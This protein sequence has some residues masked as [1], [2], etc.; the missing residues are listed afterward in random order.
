MWNINSSTCVYVVCIYWLRKSYIVH[1][2]SSF[3]KMQRFDRVTQ[4]V[5][6]NLFCTDIDCISLFL[7]VSYHCQKTIYRVF[8]FHHWMIHGSGRSSQYP[9]IINITYLLRINS[10][11]LQ[12]WLDPS[13][14][15]TGTAIASAYEKT[16]ENPQYEF[17][18]I[19][20]KELRIC[21]SIS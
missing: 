21:I 10:F 7:T 11:K 15:Y 4:K 16:D 3:S 5:T 14:F 1:I 20:K 17:A 12:E 6:V 19:P 9:M 18:I 8:T 2:P 13:W